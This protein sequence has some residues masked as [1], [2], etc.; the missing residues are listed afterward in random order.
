MLPTT[1]CATIQLRDV[2]PNARFVRTTDI[3]FSSCDTDPRRCGPG[4]LFVAIT[5]DESDDH[6][7][8]LEAV[9]NGAS[10]VLAE[11]LLP[12]SAP[13]AIVRD[14]RAA[15]GRLTHALAGDPSQNLQT[16]AIAG[17]PGKTAVAILL[18]A[19]LCA[20]GGTVAW[21]NSLASFDGEEVYD[22]PSNAANAADLA[23]WLRRSAAHRCN[24]AIVEVSTAQLATHGLAGLRADVAILHGELYADVAAGQR[25]ASARRLCTRLAKQLK[26]Q[27]AM[28][29]NVD[30]P[31]VFELL[32][33]FQYPTL[34]AALRN[35]ADVMATILERHASEQTFLLQAGPES[36][37]V[38]TTLLGDHQVSNCLSAAAAAIL[39]G[40]DLPTIARG[41]ER[42]SWIPGQL[43]RLECGQP[44]NVFID[45]GD[46][47]EA[48]ELALR[49]VRRATQGRVIALCGAK[50]NLPSEHR[51]RLGHTLE[52]FAHVQILA[53]DNPGEEAPLA[54]IHD[55]LDGFMKPERALVR[56]DR[57]GAIAWALSQARPG[58]SVV[59]CGKALDGIQQLEDGDHPW[60]DGEQARQWLYRNQ[61]APAGRPKL[62][63]F[64]G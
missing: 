15:Y 13:Q 57:E 12:V 63:V 31:A 6:E 62:R 58:D 55:L 16:F 40:V 11:R 14:T 29:A 41:I 59:L 23:D 47:P 49:S 22:L 8:A 48:V 32:G 36:V 25:S 24:Q 19:I 5:T 53:N 17:G 18:E 56:P 3:Q 43:E 34:T 52:R 37:P 54:I 26:S 64:T 51:A 2:L 4:S 39:A 28:V 38:R 20:A 60:D 44:F 30:D 7:D 61:A 27:A 21:H 10:A 33:H 9:R 46:T 42:V 1:D 35:P 50:S 45:G